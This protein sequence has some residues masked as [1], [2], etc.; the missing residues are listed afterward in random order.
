MTALPHAPLS[1]TDQSGA[2]GADW[3][4]ALARLN[5]VTRLLLT[6]LV[7][8][9]VLISL[10]WLSATVIFVG[11]LVVF[12]AC[13]VR[14]RMLA[15]R[16]IPLLIVAPLAA[17]SMALYG[18][19]GGDVY[20]QWWLVVISQ[21]SLTMAIAVVLR[22]F[23]LGLAALVLMGGLDLTATA[24]GLAQICHLPARF[25]LGTLAGMRMINLFA[26]DWRTMAQ[27]RRARGLGDTGRLRRF[28]TMA[29]ALLVFAIRRGAKLATAME[30]RGFDASTAAHRTW[31]RP[32]RMGRADAVGWL[33]AVVMVALALAVSIRLGT[34]TPVTR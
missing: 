2:S 24:D 19:P 33:V 12:L 31:A 28:A 11:E 27:A 16:M 25:V 29:F 1:G 26:A 4:G 18:K 3:S 13:G 23:A 34:F 14:A 15:R 7:A 22:I 5:P 8:I 6:V 10:D 32:S 20:F 17:I 30:A 21:R 9:P